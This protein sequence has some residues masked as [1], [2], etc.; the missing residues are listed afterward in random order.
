MIEQGLYQ[1]PSLCPYHFQFHCWESVLISI[2]NPSA[3]TGVE[4]SFCNLS[5]Q[6]LMYKE[7]FVGPEAFG[8]VNVACLTHAEPWCLAVSGREWTLSE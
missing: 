1:Y 4:K 7:W 5:R 6:I 2:N 3:S 8:N